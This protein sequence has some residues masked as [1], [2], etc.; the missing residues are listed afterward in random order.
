M[1]DM[2]ATDMHATDMHATDMHA[3]DTHGQDDHGHAEETLGPVDW[4]AWTIGAAGVAIGCLMWLC[5][6][7]AT[8]PS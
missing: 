6:V 1:T 3:T 2:H 7:L 4:T 8:L 5:F